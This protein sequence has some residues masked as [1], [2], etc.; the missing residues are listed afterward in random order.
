MLVSWYEVR[1]LKESKPLQEEAFRL[2]KERPEVENC[3]ICKSQLS[4]PLSTFSWGITH[5]DGFCTKCGL[6]IQYYH[7]I[8]WGDNRIRLAFFYPL[9]QPQS[10]LDKLASAWTGDRKT[11]TPIG[12]QIM[13]DYEKEVTVDDRAS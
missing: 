12:Q 7:Y 1:K 3:P 9:V 10:L 2:Q 6:A 13:A 4:G 5:G 8:G 11:F